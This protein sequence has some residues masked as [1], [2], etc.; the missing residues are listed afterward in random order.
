MLE[1]AWGGGGCGM[2]FCYTMDVWVFLCFDG[3]GLRGSRS[4][5]MA[6]A[7]L[8]P[9]RVDAELVTTSWRG[10]WIQDLN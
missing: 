10:R 1:S 9:L 5:L 7:C 2:P 8:L 4:E 6:V 3:V